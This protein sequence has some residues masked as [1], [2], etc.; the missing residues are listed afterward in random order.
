M[1]VTAV[2]SSMLATV[3]YDEARQ[4]LQR[5]FRNRTID[6]YFD[7]PGAVY[8]ALLGAPSRGSYFHQTIRGRF[9]YCLVTAFSPDAPAGEM[10]AGY[11]R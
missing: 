10:P 2:E 7:V 5:E 6:W 9:P 1:P 4:L 11:G 8:E 3:A